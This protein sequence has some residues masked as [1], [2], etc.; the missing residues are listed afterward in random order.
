MALTVASLICV[1]VRGKCETAEPK[2]YTCGN[3]DDDISRSTAML[4]SAASDKVPPTLAPPFMV[5][6]F[7]LHISNK[8]ILLLYGF[9]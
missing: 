8:Y 1:Q 9:C 2:V 3:D 6:V 4:C 5:I 7:V